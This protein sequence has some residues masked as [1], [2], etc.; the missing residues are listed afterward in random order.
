MKKFNYKHIYFQ[1]KNKENSRSTVKNEVRTFLQKLKLFEKRNSLPKQLSGG[2]KRRLCLGM[3]LIGDS[4]V[5]FIK[6]I[7]YCT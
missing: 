7:Y 3:A 5:C 4:S 6:C 2:Q 1:L